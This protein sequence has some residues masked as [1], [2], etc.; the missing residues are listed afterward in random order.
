M[1]IFPIPPLSRGRSGGGWDVFVAVV[2]GTPREE[3]G[4]P[5]REILYGDGGMLMD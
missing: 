3:D 4:C 2:L 5:D 1:G